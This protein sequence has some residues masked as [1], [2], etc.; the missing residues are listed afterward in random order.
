MADES[1]WARR[2]ADDKLKQREKK[3]SDQEKVIS[4]RKLIQS[5]GSEMRQQFE[6]EVL[7]CLGELKLAMDGEDVITLRKE[8]AGGRLSLHDPKS[9][10]EIIG[11]PFH[12]EYGEMPTLWGEYKLVPQGTNDVVWRDKYN[13][14]WTTENL[15]RFIVQKA[16]EQVS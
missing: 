10:K 4:D 13:S 9:G 6:N 14:N 2:L 5:R 12:P 16:F 7:K 3:Q 8:S 11:M 1:H 15:A